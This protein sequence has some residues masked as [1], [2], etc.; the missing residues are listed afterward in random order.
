MQGHLGY[1]KAGEQMLLV[2]LYYEVD[3]AR[4]SYCHVLLS[5]L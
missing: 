2:V 5:L 3:P 1:S 4:D